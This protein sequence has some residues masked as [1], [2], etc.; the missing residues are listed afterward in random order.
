MTNLSQDFKPSRTAQRKHYTV[1]LYV[2]FITSKDANEY[3]IIRI[4]NLIFEYSFVF[5]KYAYRA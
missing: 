4:V 3:S 1:D 2:G 5:I